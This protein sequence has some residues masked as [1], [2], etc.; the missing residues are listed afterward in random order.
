MEQDEE[1]IQMISTN[2]FEVNFPDFQAQ[3]NTTLQTIVDL[4]DQLQQLIQENLRI[5]KENQDLKEKIAQ[6]IILS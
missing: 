4:S 6:K 3:I 2:R 1:E 5:R